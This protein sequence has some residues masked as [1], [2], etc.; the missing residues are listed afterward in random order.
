MNNERL[1][2]I[3][4]IAFVALIAFFCWC[5][6]SKSVRTEKKGWKIIGL[7]VVAF[8]VF[9]VWYHMPIS[10]KQTVQVCAYE[11]QDCPVELE[12]EV[13]V[14]RSYLYG[15]CVYGTVRMPD[16]IYSNIGRNYHSSNPYLKP[17]ERTLRASL[18]DTSNTNPYDA[19][20]SF[21]S[22]TFT[23]RWDWRKI[24]FV[25]VLDHLPDSNDSVWYRTDWALWNEMKG[26]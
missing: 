3:I 6:S 15:T 25:D 11:A 14:L 26:S 7:L 18:Y 22:A 17:W 19:L 12:I 13:E 4:G 8:V 9:T 2:L 23:F 21:L 20:D 24:I 16:G 1:I 10:C 5:Y